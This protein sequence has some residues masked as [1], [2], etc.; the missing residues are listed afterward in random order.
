MTKGNAKIW[1]LGLKI[2][3]DAPIC[4]SLVLD[5]VLYGFLPVFFNQA[6]IC[7]GPSSTALFFSIGKAGELIPVKA[8]SI[9]AVVKKVRLLDFHPPMKGQTSQIP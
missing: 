3:F 1:I 9:F 4:P 6:Q 7:H 8:I 5:L 2:H